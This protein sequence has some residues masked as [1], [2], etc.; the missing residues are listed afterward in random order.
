MSFL[1]T[2]SVSV[3]RSNKSL[4]SQ[5]TPFRTPY[6]PSLSVSISFPTLGRTKQQFKDECDVNL[7]M[8][9]YMKTGILGDG[10]EPPPPRYMDVS[11]PFTYH[12]AMNFVAEAQGQFY[13]LPSSIRSRFGNDPGELLAFLDNPYNV[14]EGIALGLIR[15]PN[16]PAPTVP[17]GTSKRD[18]EPSGSSG[19]SAPENAPT[20]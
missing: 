3:H 15:D 14:Q 5:S 2:T 9:R 11:A 4:T 8:S 16:T 17:F 6:S 20:N 7:L 10:S 18:S 19:V 12:E 1:P 13:D